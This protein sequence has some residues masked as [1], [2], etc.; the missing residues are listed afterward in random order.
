MKM[1]KPFEDFFTQ[2][3]E[4]NEHKLS[5]R[6]K[7]LSP[8]MKKSVDE[9]FKF[10]ESDPSDFLAKFEKFIEKTAKKNKVEAVALMKYFEKET[11]EA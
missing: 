8:R 2:L 6:Y 11:L 5:D 1:Y 3:Q 10:L 7:L 4:K 9:V